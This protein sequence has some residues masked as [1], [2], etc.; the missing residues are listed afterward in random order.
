[1]ESEDWAVLWEGFMRKLHWKCF[2]PGSGLCFLDITFNLKKRG[3][4]LCEEA[5]QVYCLRSLS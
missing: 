3:E 4:A 5:Y 2:L 1:M